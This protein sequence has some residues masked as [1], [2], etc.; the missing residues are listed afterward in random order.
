MSIPAIVC[1]VNCQTRALPVQR[2]VYVK[3]V[4]G[5][6]GCILLSQGLCFCFC[7]FEPG[8]SSL[9]PGHGYDLFRGLCQ[10]ESLNEGKARPAA[11]CGQQSPA[12]SCRA[13]GL[14][15]PQVDGYTTA[16]SGEAGEPSS[17]RL[18]ACAR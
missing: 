12:L 16:N 10:M 15:R 14:H 6:A 11:R 8:E 18:R 7:P 3:D 5:V 2:P 4:L 1:I 13:S 17:C 9:S